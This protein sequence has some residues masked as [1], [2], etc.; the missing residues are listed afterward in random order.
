M[1][2]PAYTLGQVYEKYHDRDDKILYLLL[3][4]QN[5]FWL[6]ALNYFDSILLFNKSIMTDK[7]PEED[8]HSDKRERTEKK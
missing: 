8:R 2:T 7:Y 3:L 5:S 6:F 4:R 1:L